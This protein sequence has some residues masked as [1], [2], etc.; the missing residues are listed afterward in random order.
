MNR[1]AYYINKREIRLGGRNPSHLK[2]Q[3]MQQRSTSRLAW[4]KRMADLRRIH[5]DIA[6]KLASL[7]V[8]EARFE[9][10]A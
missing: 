5:L 3:A 10:L 9:P 7:R 6:P 8:V 2:T 1:E 4:L